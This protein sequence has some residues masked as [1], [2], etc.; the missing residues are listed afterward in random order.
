[1]TQ[2]F[3][4]V[5]EAVVQFCLEMGEWRTARDEDFL[6]MLDEIGYS[7]RVA[8]PD[9]PE[10]SCW[11]SLQTFQRGYGWIRLA[12]RQTPMHRFAWNMVYDEIPAGLV[13]MHRCD[14][15]ACFR[16][17]HLMLGTQAANTRDMQMKG[18]ARGGPPTGAD[19]PRGM[20][21]LNEAAVAEILELA[22]SGARPYMIAA[23]FGVSQTTIGD[24]LKR[25][26]WGHVPRPEMKR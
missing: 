25:G 18:R 9:F 22:A 10:I 14:N 23:V 6:A 16:P 20:A 1:V 4:D 7:Y 24:I 26:A 12:K 5:P 13:V 3:Q 17:T 2:T 21:K 19:H 11:E 8:T 15:P